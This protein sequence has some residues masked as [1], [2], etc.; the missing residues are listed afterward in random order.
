MVLNLDPFNPG[1]FS[2]NLQTHPMQGGFLANPP[3]QMTFLGRGQTTTPT[4]LIAR[5]QST[6]PPGDQCTTTP[7]IGR[8]ECDSEAQGCD[9]S[10]DKGC[11]MSDHVKVV[12]T[13]GV[14]DDSGCIVEKVKDVS[15]NGTDEKNATEEKAA[16]KREQKKKRESICLPIN[17]D[18]R[19]KLQC[20]LVS[21]QSEVLQAPFLR[22]SENVQ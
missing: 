6:T 13:P 15:L 5:G 7:P 10:S 16:P 19:T 14:Q 20:K 2:N 21:L 1:L 12:L 22:L 3:A 17:S 18:I 8:N 11:D 9:D 4:R